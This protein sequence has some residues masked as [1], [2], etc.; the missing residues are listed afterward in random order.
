MFL[1]MGAAAKQALLEI[2]DNRYSSAW[3][4]VFFENDRIIGQNYQ[5]LLN[6]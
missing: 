3:N 2:S 4:E 5:Q 6:L 1:F